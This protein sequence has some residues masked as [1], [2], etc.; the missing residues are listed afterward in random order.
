MA[1]RALA[2]YSPRPPGRPGA[3]PGSPR[4]RSPPGGRTGPE[5]GG[6]ARRGTE[7]G[8]RRAGVGGREETAGA[9]PTRSWEVAVCRPQT[10]CPV[11]GRGDRG[12]SARPAGREQKC[13]PDALPGFAA[14]SWAEPGSRGPASLGNLHKL[15]R[16]PSL[17]SAGSRGAMGVRGGASKERI[18]NR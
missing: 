10:G 2:A 12:A 18:E 3:A 8:T 11:C 5:D 17:R 13:Y 15:G 1:P 4:S 16:V 14:T 6:G 7:E 9:A